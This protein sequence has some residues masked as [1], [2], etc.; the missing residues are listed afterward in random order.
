MSIADKNL[1]VKSLENQLGAVLTVTQM[2]AVMQ[3]VS[4]E[5]SRYNLEHADEEAVPM[6]LVNAFIDTKKVEGRSDLT[7]ERYTYIIRRFLEKVKVPVEKVN[8]YHLR[9]YL[10][11]EKQRGVSDGTLEGAREVFSSFF[12]WLYKESLIPTNP[13][14]NLSA[15]K[16]Q[17][18][19][20]LPYSDIDI[21]RM[22]EGCKTDR[23]RA[24]VFFLLA[25]GCRISEVCA[26]NRNDLDLNA[27]ECTVLGKGNKERTVYFDS[28]TA[29]MLKRYLDS[30]TD[31]EPAL[32][33]SARRKQRLEPA[34]VRY[35]LKSIEGKQGELSNVHP[36]RFR[37][38]LATGL[39]D[40][41]M[42]IQDVAAILGHDKLD[43]TMKYVYLSKENIKSSYRRYTK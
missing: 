27:M 35:I 9:N 15:I 23:D 20:R 17:K 40:S 10:S 8:V 34:C 19:I 13:C 12:G 29:L 36:H 4:A 24:I 26:L 42:P 6:D 38:T 2:T 18:K 11:S 41:G 33:L 21:Q 39:I 3:I 25:T 16:C 43:T 7:L 28:V 30:R 5:L 22:K 1:L 32:F 31:D 14:N 37:R